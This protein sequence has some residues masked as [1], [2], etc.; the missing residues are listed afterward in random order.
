[1]HDTA[2]SRI[3]GRSAND[4]RRYRQRT[5]RNQLT[6]AS[7]TRYA[8]TVHL[9]SSDPRAVLPAPP[10]RLAVLGNAAGTTARAY[11]HYFPRTA[12]DAVEIDPKVTLFPSGDGAYNLR[13]ALDVQLPSVADPAI[14][15]ELVAGAHQV[16][17]YSNATRGNIEVALSANGQALEPRE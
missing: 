11:G 6:P 17:P 7:V 2:R 8:G 14:A 12:I 15:R 13:V 10:R 16:C 4:R 3:F 5:A 1:M 9:T